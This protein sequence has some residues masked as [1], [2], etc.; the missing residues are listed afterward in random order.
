M[1]DS[2]DFYLWE[3][4]SAGQ[5]VQLVRKS[6]L[7]AV[8]KNFRQ[9]VF[10]SNTVSSDVDNIESHVTAVCCSSD[11]SGILIGTDNGLIALIGVSDTKGLLMPSADDIISSNRI[12]SW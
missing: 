11:N 5:S 3:L 2:N 6:H 10:N 1:T 12:L 8:T 7:N 9:N 4:V